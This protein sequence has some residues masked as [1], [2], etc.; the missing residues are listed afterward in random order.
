M[1]VIRTY[2]LLFSNDRFG[3]NRPLS[4]S[5]GKVSSIISF[6][7]LDFDKLSQRIY[8]DANYLYHK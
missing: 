8:S 6:R 7:Y 2:G 5:K 3:F 4:L 1:A